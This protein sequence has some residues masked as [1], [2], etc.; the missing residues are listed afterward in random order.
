MS[1]HSPMRNRRAS[2]RD[3]AALSR[4][5]AASA[6][7]ILGACVS[8]TAVAAPG[9][10]NEA[11][12]V[13]GVMDLQ[14]LSRGLG[15]GMKLGIETALK[16][17][18]VRERRIDFVVLNDNYSPPKTIEATNELVQE[19]IFAMIGNVGTPTAKVSLPILAD[20][21]VPALGFFTGAGILRPGVG[22][23][24][25]FRAS[26][27]QETA[28]VINAAL[29]AGIKPNEVCA[30]VQNDAY[31]MAGVEGI[32]RALAPH[33]GLEEVVAILE[34]MIV[35]EGDNPPR[36][37]MGPVG[38]YTR[39][40]VFAR[41]GYR[42]LKSWEA[43]TGA[44]C[45]LV[46]SVGAYPAIAQFAAYARAKG[47]RW[48][49]SAVSFTGADNYR[50]ELK[51]LGVTDGIIMTQVV[52]PL[53]SDLP[54]VEEARKALGSDFGYVSLEGYIVGKLFLAA[55]ERIE[56]PITRQSFLDAL[57]GES[58]SLDGLYM[59]FTS[60]NQGS[61]LVAITYLDQGGYRAMRP[62]DWRWAL[63]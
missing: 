58:F 31:G 49:V 61:D 11:I 62:A 60:D 24:I 20:H 8:L 25:N 5:L 48:I 33:E 15:Q 4:A 45:R 36:N 18:R 7:T 6:A 59:D 12:R 32:R 23:I 41:D 19:G 17:Q 37:H 3:K 51:R 50:S 54:I 26:Y 14:G 29:N 16:G 39:N 56:G 44:R 2:S 43:S 38:V 53:D 35:M 27:I 28:A 30:Y 63:R 47:E 55:L 34:D 13:G 10:T 40:T 57:G 42:S 22:D 52:P 21:G 1:E 9:V 46:V